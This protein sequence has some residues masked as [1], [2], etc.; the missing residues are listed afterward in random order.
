LPSF[1][2]MISGAAQ[3]LRHLPATDPLR[4]SLAD[5]IAALRP[6]DYRW[7]TN[8]SDVA[9]RLLG[10]GSLQSRR[11]RSPRSRDVAETYAIDR[12][13]DAERLQSARRREDPNS[14]AIS[15]PGKR[16]GDKSTAS[17]H[18]RRHLS[19]VRRLGAEHPGSFTSSKMG[20]GSRRLPRTPIQERKKWYGSSGKASSRWSSSG[21]ACVREAITRA[22]KERHPRRPTSTTRAQR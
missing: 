4:A 20:I 16:R 8:P 10:R 22:G 7:G 9:R 11:R 15:G 5:P 19:K 12:A 21:T 13:T 6:W 2:R 3:V 17:A 18:H 1:A 14:S